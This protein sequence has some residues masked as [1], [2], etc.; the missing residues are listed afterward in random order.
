[1][2][3]LL[4][5][6]EP[7]V[8]EIFRHLHENPEVSWKEFQTTSYI[9]KVI[10]QNGIEVTTFSDMPGVI[11]KWSPVDSISNLTIGLRADMDALLQ[12]VDGTF[13]ANHSCGHDAHMTIVLGVLLLLR[14][15]KIILPGTLKF[16]FQ[17]AEEVGE[18]ALKIIEKQVLDDVD[19]LYG[20][21]LRPI[22]EIK[23]GQATSGIIHGS[24]DT[25]FGEIHGFD[26]H[27]A[28]PH[29]TLNAIEVISAIVEQIKGIRLNPQLSYSVKMTQV[30]AGGENAN[31][32]P[33][34]SK[35]SLDLRA[36]TNEAMDELIEKVDD[37]LNK[38][39]VFYQCQISFKHKER[40]YAA[41]VDQEAAEFMEKAI[42]N[43]LGAKGLVGPI[44]TPGGE[45]F[46]F[47][48]KER[49][50]IKATMLGVGCDLEPGLHH[51]NMVFNQDAIFTGIEILTRVVIETFE[52]YNK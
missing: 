38:M 11:G 13:R 19:F 9:S 35:F 34:S 12:D 18:G 29:L 47:Y 10:Q 3:E 49:P 15:M 52:K 24:A 50:A 26:G 5:E 43:T 51:P 41:S 6:I 33:G 16:I 40:V 48:T 21:H 31:I 39:S 14:K 30:S 1:M 45:D 23:N 27:G 22:Q 46:H 25:V 7:Q 4:K 36:Q 2:K 37:V 44:I 42:E 17:P 28:R 32:I 20:L 8:L